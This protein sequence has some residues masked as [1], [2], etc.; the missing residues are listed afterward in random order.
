LFAIVATT[1][2]P[3]L[4]PGEE[5]YGLADPVR[6]PYPYFEVISKIGL[7][8][9]LALLIWKLGEWFF[10]DR[11]ERKILPPPDPMKVA[12][13]AIKRLKQSPVLEEGKLKEVCERLALI[14]KVFLKDKFNLG[15]GAA[16]TSSELIESLRRNKITNSAVRQTSELFD[17]CDQIKFAKGTL[18]EDKTPLEL[19]NSFEELLIS[20]DW[21]K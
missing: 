9:V 12:I 1:T 20:G 18:G 19:I 11:R 7:W 4:P 13:R 3:T 5:I 8:V 16:S 2:L 6:L 21:K 15:I 10:A 17:I 14:L